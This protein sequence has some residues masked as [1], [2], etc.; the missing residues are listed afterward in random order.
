LSQ[1]FGLKEQSIY[2]DLVE[3]NEMDPNGVVKSEVNDNN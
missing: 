3:A 2:T 1:Q